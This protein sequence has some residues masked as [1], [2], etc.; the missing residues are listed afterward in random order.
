L[1]D[2]APSGHGFG[3]DDFFTILDFANQIF[4]GKNPESGTAFD[5]ITNPNLVG[6]AWEAPAPISE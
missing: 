2:H 1:Y 6:F 4:Y 3:D 5:Q